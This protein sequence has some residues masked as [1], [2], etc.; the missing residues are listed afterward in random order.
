M[1]GLTHYMLA[2]EAERKGDQAGAVAELEEALRLEPD[3]GYWHSA[4]ATI[5]NK[6][7]DAR[8]AAKECAQ[9]AELSPD[10]AAPAA[11]CGLKGGAEAEKKVDGNPQGEDQGGV[12]VF[13]PKGDVT[14]P[15]PTYKPDPPYSEKAR[16]VKYQGTTVL[17]L[18]VNAQGDVE[19]A[20]IVKPLE[21]G[22]DQNALRTVRT[23]KFKPAT[24]NGVGVPVRI[25]V[26][27]SFRLF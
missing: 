24:R 21:L 2:Q 14:A 8:G 11:G 3:E 6:R 10:D 17:W 13:K 16:M 12:A 9:A 27:V 4:L 18:V 26:Q 19:R 7:G 25:M 15:Y 5:L 20:N 23:W 22:L 1:L